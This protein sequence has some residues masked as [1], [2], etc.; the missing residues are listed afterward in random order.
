MENSDTLCKREKVKG[1]VKFLAINGVDATDENI[2]NKSYPLTKIVYAI[3]KKS[4]PQD[5]SARKLIKWILT[6]EG[7][8]V[9]EAGGYVR[10]TK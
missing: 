10:N 8:K 2:T 3:T 7:Q 6:D 4:E 9:V 5:S 1:N